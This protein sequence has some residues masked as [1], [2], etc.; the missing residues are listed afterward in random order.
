MGK[1]TPRFSILRTLLG[2]KKNPRRNTFKA[3]RDGS[4]PAGAPQKSM[5]EL[6]VY[7]AFADSQDMS[8]RIVGSCCRKALMSHEGSA[9]PLL[10]VCRGV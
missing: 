8:G 10:Q 3:Q 1:A 2:E 6:L 7:P 9:L 4:I 5:K